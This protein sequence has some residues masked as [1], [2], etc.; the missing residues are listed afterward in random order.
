MEIRTWKRKASIA[1]ALRD[2]QHDILKSGQLKPG[3]YRRSG[4]L[5]WRVGSEVPGHLSLTKASSPSDFRPRSWFRRLVLRGA[6]NVMAP[7]IVTRGSDFG[8]SGGIRNRTGGF[9]FFNPDKL[10]V[11]HVKS[12]PLFTDAYRMLRDSLTQYVRAP[13]YNILDAQDQMDESFVEGESLSNVDPLIRVDAVKNFLLSLS[14]L[15]TLHLQIDTNRIL[16][17]ASARGF[18]AQLPAEL[19]ESMESVM[20][21]GIMDSA[22]VV[23]SHGDA[24]IENALVD[25]YGN[26][27]LVDWDPL[28][29]ALRP[30]WFDPL[31]LLGMQSFDLMAAFRRG[32]FDSA[33]ARVWIAHTGGA[34]DFIQD[35]SAMVATMCVAFANSLYPQTED[36]EAFVSRAWRDWQFW[37]ASA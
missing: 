34:P 12:D 10:T 30:F 6:V 36:N 29:L 21:A 19:L 25:E 37:V 7:P 23:P 35:R 22:C 1:V 28:V 20:N 32:E 15:A 13:A 8:A 3:V 9:L 17:D 27:V 11:R 2:A 26:L 4:R 14:E 16:G 31:R 33:L 18:D 5:Y 24:C